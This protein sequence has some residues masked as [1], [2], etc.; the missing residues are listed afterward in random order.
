[1]PGGDCQPADR[2]HQSGGGAEAGAGAH[3]DRLHVL[4]DLGDQPVRHGGDGPEHL[5]PPVLCVQKPTRSADGGAAMRWRKKKGLAR[6]GLPPRLAL[7]L[8]VLLVEV[9]EHANLSTRVSCE[10]QNPGLRGRRG[11][12]G[13]RAGLVLFVQPRL[14]PVPAAVKLPGLRLRQKLDMEQ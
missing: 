11:A 5:L 7:V 13:G 1:M 3:E 8:L 6:T 2:R 12:L 4:V 9:G 14:Q 10:P